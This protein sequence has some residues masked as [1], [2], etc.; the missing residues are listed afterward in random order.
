MTR[1]LSKTYLEVD[2]FKLNLAYWESLVGVSYL[3]LRLDVLLVME[4]VHW[5][6]RLDIKIGASLLGLECHIHTV[7]VM[8]MEIQ[9]FLAYRKNKQKY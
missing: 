8:I 9:G 5:L 2:W 3:G 4:D 6:T 7:V 1:W